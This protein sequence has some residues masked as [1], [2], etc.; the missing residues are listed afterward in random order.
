MMKGQGETIANGTTSHDEEEADQE[1][2]VGRSRAKRTGGS[3]AEV[4]GALL[5]RRE[6][7][8]EVRARSIA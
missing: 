4:E 5:G 7:T 3:E 2:I 8:A 6:N 1:I